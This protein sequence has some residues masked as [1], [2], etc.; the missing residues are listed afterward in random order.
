MTRKHRIHR[1]D[2]H[3]K[4]SN[5]LYDQWEGVIISDATVALSNRL[6]GKSLESRRRELRLQ[7][8]ALPRSAAAFLENF[9]RYFGSMRD[10]YGTPEAR[11]YFADLRGGDDDESTAPGFNFA[12]GAE[13]MA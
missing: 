3:R 13:E 4:R 8:S 6:L 9:D 5:D 1:R 10:V 12:S 11:A 2:S 7:Q